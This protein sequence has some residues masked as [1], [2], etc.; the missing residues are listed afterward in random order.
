LW[1]LI[2][3]VFGL[4]LLVRCLYVWQ[5]RSAPFFD[6]RVGDAAAYHDWAR[7]IAAGDWLGQGVFYQAPLYPYFLAVIY[8]IFGDGV[9]TVRLIQA[10]IGAGSCALIGASGAS[11]YGR[12]GVI[13]GVGL[14]IYPPAI[15]FDGLLEKSALVTFFTAALIALLAIR[16]DVMTLRGWLTAGALI[17]LLALTRENALVLLIPALAWA[18]FTAPR[19]AAAAGALAAG[20]VLILLPIGL[21]NLA[22]GG[23]F[24]L[25]TSQFGPNFYIGNHA[26]ARGTYEALVEGHGNASDEREDAT[27]LAEQSAG[28]KLTAGEVSGYW[29]SRALDYIRSQPVDWLALMARKAALLFNMNEISDTESM[30]VYGD[31][32]WSLEILPL[33]FGVL[34]LLAVLGAIATIPEWRRLWFLYGL[35]AVYAISVVAFY[36]FARYRFPLVPVLLLFATG[37][38]VHRQ[39]LRESRLLPFTITAAIGAMILTALPLDDRLAARATNYLSIAAGL[40]KDPAR[41]A[42]AAGFYKRAL[43][44]A[45]QFPAAQFGL[46]TL[47]AGAGRPAEAIPYYRAALVSWP[48]YAE[49]H[50]NLARA[51]ADTGQP[52][53]AASEYTEALRI[54]PA[55]ADTHFA[56]AKTLLAMERPDAAAEQYRQGLGARP[57]DVK[58]LAGLGVALTQ[59]GHPDEA[60]ASYHRALELDPEDATAHN[61]LGWTLASQGKVADAIPQFERALALDPGYAG[62][63][64]NLEQAR[65]IIGQK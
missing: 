40:A 53:E 34:L 62:A 3:G 60:I 51:F 50:Y 36:V 23:E 6:L 65:A 10:L 37:A 18:A 30:D 24:Y 55:D 39:R 11:L 61:N 1:P 5:I 58:A 44:V 64:A 26:G 45:P 32:S 28:H 16:P 52:R 4:A 19:R 41:S 20:C 15:F 47:L 43:D 14:A 31:Y 29:T 57:D 12:L 25:T 27:R 7:R 13:A 59:L 35:A 42:E 63:R 46:G 49:A 54:R 17:G 56:F 21:R 9:M 48:G 38:I 2:L 8:R 22:R 33:H